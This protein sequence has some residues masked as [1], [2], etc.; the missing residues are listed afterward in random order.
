MVAIT[1]DKDLLQAVHEH[2]PDIT[3]GALAEAAGISSSNIARSLANHRKAKLVKADALELTPEGARLAGVSPPTLRRAD[4]EAGTPPP[5][6]SVNG[7]GTSAP[8]NEI[9]PSGLN[10]RK[11]FDEASIAELAESLIA[12]GQIQEMVVRQARAGSDA[13]INWEVVA[14]ERRWKAFKLL[15]DQ[16][17]LPADQPVRIHVRDLDDVEVLELAVM[18]NR[19]REDVHPME[20]AQ[21]IAALQDAR[22]A[23]GSKTDARAV[24]REIGEKL[25]LTERWAQ[26]RVNMVRRLSPKVQKAMMEGVFNSV[27][28]ADELGRWPHEIQEQAVKQIGANWNPITTEKQLKNWLSGDRIPV[29]EQPFEVDAYTSAGGALSDPDDQGIVHFVNSG[30]A[31]ELAATA[32][33]EQAAQLT[34]K[35]GYAR[36][37]F[38]ANWHS[39]WDFPKP[40][41]L[42]PKA[43]ED[44]HQVL[45][46]IDSNTLKVK[47]YHPIIKRTS[48][49]A[50]RRKDDATKSGGDSG[51][52]QA[53]PL[54]R[55]LW[56]LGA[57][58]RT[59]TLREAIWGDAGLA[60]ALMIVA[61]TSNTSWDPTAVRVKADLPSGDAGEIGI[62]TSHVDLIL[63]NK[64]NGFNAKG[65]VADRR[66]ALLA[67]IENPDLVDAL[68]AA[69]VAD[70]TIDC[71][72]TAG[73]GAAGEAIA[74]A[75]AGYAQN[76]TGE[77]ID[78]AWAK[79]YN[80][81]Q[82]AGMIDAYKL[83]LDTAEVA[84]LKKKEADAAIAEAVG[85]DHHPIEAR[86]VNETKARKLEE[87]LLRGVKV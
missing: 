62:G 73:A 81:A 15:I 49:E 82:Q 23:D 31:R 14:G 19:Q 72:W 79:K 38:E 26:I 41:E 45:Y 24:C 21:A 39:S 34:Q 11:T 10:Y 13:G 7:G 42:D 50:W 75:D 64:L 17:R 9:R 80:K 8:W 87:K 12:K 61:L 65:E 57:R 85:T 55:G 84:G 36:E 58:A 67:L 68:F 33:K 60:K 25:G 3:S 70:F 29:G 48:Y 86:F 22:L 40:K 63:E 69:L 5:S 37:A 71:D 54:A 78:A 74:M 32:A 16:G 27:K 56:H 1:F 44:L 35:K 30:L 4:E 77:I 52:P 20:E 2:G 83:H 46:L 76:P 59:E 6:A 28:W 66:K 18:E 43:P 53:K 47:L 51:A